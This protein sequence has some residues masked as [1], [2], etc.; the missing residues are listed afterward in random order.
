MRERVKELG[1]TMHIR[2]GVDGTVLMIKI[3]IP[4][5]SRSALGSAM[6]GIGQGA[7]PA[8]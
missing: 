3:P 4:G 8:A 1:G 2:S 7:S 6:Q 5:Q